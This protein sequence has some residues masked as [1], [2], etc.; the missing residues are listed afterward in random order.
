M[1]ERV[2]SLR[3]DAGLKGWARTHRLCTL[4]IKARYRRLDDFAAA[5]GVSRGLISQVI[6]GLSRSPKVNPI[7][8]DLVGVP[9]NRLF[10]KNL[11]KAA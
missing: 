6:T 10:P 8:A 1:A 4:A 9:E 5:I 7:I 11:R 3:M 2:V